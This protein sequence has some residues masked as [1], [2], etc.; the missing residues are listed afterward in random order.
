VPS[1][2]LDAQ[3]DPAQRLATS[4]PAIQL[5]AAHRSTAVDGVEIHRGRARVR[6]ILGPSRHVERRA[7]VE[8]DVVIDELAEERRA[9]RLR[10]AVRIVG[11]ERW[12]G[13]EP[14]RADLE[15]ILRI[16]DAA[17]FA[18]LVE[19]G[20]ELRT[21]RCERRQVEDPSETILADM[22]S[23]SLRVRGR[24]RAHHADARRHCAGRAECAEKAAAAHSIGRLLRV[25]RTAGGR[26]RFFELLIHWSSHWISPLLM[27]PETCEATRASRPSGARAHAPTC[28]ARRRVTAA[29][30]ISLFELVTSP[31]RKRLSLRLRGALPLFDG[32][33]HR[34]IRANVRESARACRR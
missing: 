3:L 23:D 17:D 1:T 19:R 11:A 4:A 32:L 2:V 29:N 6:R 21:G 34:L 22:C 8:R 25:H 20:G 10:G 24:A 5:R 26:G 7:Q 30:R 27:V 31:V 28:A 9:G 16:H 15:R 33:S 13:D 18:E 12:L 14:H